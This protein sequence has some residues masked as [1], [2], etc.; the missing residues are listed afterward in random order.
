M[1]PAH[2]IVC[3]RTGNWAAALRAWLP[4][5]SS[6][7]WQTRSLVESRARLCEAPSSVVAVECSAERVVEVCGW[8]REAAIEFPRMRAVVLAEPGSR[9]AECVWRASGAQQIVD[10]PQRLDRLARWIVRHLDQIPRPPRSPR[11]WTWERMPWRGRRGD[12]LPED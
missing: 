8:L 9:V 1:S 3:E 11:Q 4:A 12:S 7:I 2:V 10:S 5:G 6:E